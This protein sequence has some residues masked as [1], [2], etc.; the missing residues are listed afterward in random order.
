MSVCLYDG[1]IWRVDIEE[2]LE[3]EQLFVFFLNGHIED[4]VVFYNH[5]GEYKGC[6]SY[7]S[8]L[9][10]SN[11]AEAII[12]EQLILGDSF[13]K[14]VQKLLKND[15]NICLPVFNQNMEI[16]YLVKNKMCSIGMEQK[17]EE[18]KEFVD[19]SMLES[20]GFFDKHIHIKGISDVLW[21]FRE[22]LISLDVPV[23]V[24]GQEWEKFEIKTEK[25]YDKKAI[26][27]DENF[28]ILDDMHSKYREWINDDYLEL[29]K[30]FEEP[31]S[32]LRIK[33]QDKEKILFYVPSF[34]YFIDT[35]SPLI[36]KYLSDQTKE[37]LILI[38]RLETVVRKGQANIR[39]TTEIIKNIKNAGGRCYNL[40]DGIEKLCSYK[41][42][43]CYF[44]C[45]Y[46]GGLPLGL[47]KA[48]R[49]VVA[50]QTTAI[51]THMY[52]L[53]NKF[54]EIFS[55]QA[56]KEVDYFVSTEFLA[57]W[58]CQ[59]VEQWNNKILQFGYPKLDTLF[60][61]LSY[62]I[63]VPDE[64]KKRI[65]NK[66]V[67]LLTTSKIEQ[68]WLDYLGAH[69]DILAIWR[70]HPVLIAGK[71]KRKEVETLCAKYGLIL[72]DNISYYLSFYV[73]DAHVAS[74]L[75][76]ITYN[77][78]YFRKPICTYGS[79]EN[80]RAKVIDYRQEVW[81]KMCY[82]AEKTEDVLDFFEMIRCNT[83]N[84]KLNIK[85]KNMSILRE[86]DGKVCDRIYRY[87]ESI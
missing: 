46:S 28:Q 69:D 59:R 43:V 78:L 3:R 68:I 50:L 40:G 11:Y 73:S 64:W 10:A 7:G 62:G 56:M 70:P 14:D 79:Y 63:D 8:L 71:Q 19:D 41:Y 67:I 31:K 48:S 66:K 29:K 85:E 6:I 30:L 27:V 12:S 87:F 42:K 51:Y 16:I 25:C 84:D 21:H 23:S 80:S 58:I 82:Y 33:C 65:G 35:I 38:P 77:Y 45:E 4:V 75:S 61:V 57:H 13:W 15:K 47:R 53:E 9:N 44:C 72:D 36:F 37:C 60:N 86:F 83:N 20:M 49:F 74:P 34:S 1:H 32:D 2:Y 24:E 81:Y 26:V 18:L 39:K 76:S 5:D 54:E 22:W 17:L 55:E 52:R